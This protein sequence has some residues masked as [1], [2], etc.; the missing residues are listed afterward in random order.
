LADDLHHLRP[1]VNMPSEGVV[2]SASY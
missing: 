2:V 1:Q